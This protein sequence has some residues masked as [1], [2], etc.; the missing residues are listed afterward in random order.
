MMKVVELLCL[1]SEL[2]TDMLLDT[3]EEAL[4]KI[5]ISGSVLDTVVNDLGLAE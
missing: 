3:L 2:G 5:G 4:V 1:L